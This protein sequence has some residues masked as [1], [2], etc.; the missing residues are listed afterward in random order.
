MADPD[1]IPQMDAFDRLTVGLYRAGLL[2]Q[3]L[4]LFVISATE[5]GW[6]ARDVGPLAMLTAVAL[7]VGNLHL[8][9]KRIRWL[10]STSGWLG[11]VLVVAAATLP[12]SAWVEALLHYAGL[13]FLFVVTSALA[14][15]ERFCFR[16]PGLQAVPV[17]LAGGVA[18]GLFGFG[19]LTAVALGLSGLVVA[20]LAVAKLR[21]PVHVDIGNK[22]AYQV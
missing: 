8:Y 15:K 20:L 12:E 1:H 2:G 4:G 14:L 10:I 16:L 11:A 22:D 21:M 19:T 6:A 3:A 5:I 13:G 7:S 18:T 9:D 17:A